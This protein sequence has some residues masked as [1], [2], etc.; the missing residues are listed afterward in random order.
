ME[1][2]DGTNYSDFGRLFHTRVKMASS[3][4]GI[5]MCVFYIDGFYPDS[6]CRWIVRAVEDPMFAYSISE[7]EDFCDKCVVSIVPSFE[8][9]RFHLF[10]T[11]GSICAAL[12]S[13]SLPLLKD[14]FLV[15]A[16]GV[17]KQVFT[18][19]IFN[20]LYETHKKII[21]PEEATYAVSLIHELFHSID[22]SGDD[23]VSWEEFT[24]FVI[25][26]I[27]EING[28]VAAA[29]ADEYVI[30]YE[31]DFIA[32]DRFLSSH[33][34]VISMKYVSETK[35]I[36]IVPAESELIY[37]F[38]SNTF[39]L[40]S[41]INPASI[42][43]PG[44]IS[45]ED[46]IPAERRENTR[47]K[48]CFIF[49]VVYL[50]GKDFYCFSS[51]DHSI[52]VCKEIV[53]LGGKRVT[54]NQV[55]RIVHSLLHPMLCWSHNSQVLCSIST[56]NILFG[57]NID[58]GVPIYQST[59]HNSVVTALIV[60]RNLDVFVTASMDKHIILQS[61]GTGRVKAVL[62]GH[63]RGIKCVDANSEVVIS[64]G[65]EGEAKVWSLDGK[66][67]CLRLQ[68]HRTFI[69]AVKLMTERAFSE[70]DHR[71][72]TGIRSVYIRPSL[73]T[74]TFFLVAD[75]GEFRI[76]DIWVSE[77]FVE[78]PIRAALQAFEMY[79]PQMP[80]NRLKF[81]A[82]SFDDVQKISSFHATIYA[83]GSKLLKFKPK[84]RAKDFLTAACCT[85]NA[86]FGII[87]LAVGRNVFQY[88]Y[89]NRTCH[90]F[91]ESS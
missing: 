27:V 39:H 53:I 70:R 44:N 35:T 61:A 5:C 84:K 45:H 25:K 3:Y 59:R 30:E 65:F 22:F 73:V 83:C 78:P 21:E 48:R 79:N 23:L 68:G 24:A 51:D 9:F 14:K 10:G 33:I 13:Q 87:M 60:I 89:A 31:E 18:E 91:P 1:C 46:Q 49:D 56:S 54:Y 47:K 41:Q 57:W 28:E 43:D 34:P 85:Y 40:R 7:Q 36:L 90:S 58:T 55:S 16:D 42:I 4:Q 2:S 52:T 82:L 50:S 71:A 20:N 11:V 19:L 75:D 37:V 74:I 29:E 81:I 32:R 88:E 17:S 38:N 72:V 77:K 62:K 69:V 80:M 8:K 64:G 12:S 26:T 67:V 76:W 66:D 6:R 63:A 15:F 86:A